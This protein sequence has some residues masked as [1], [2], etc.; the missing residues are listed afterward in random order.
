[1]KVVK[2]VNNKACEL[3][4]I[5]LKLKGVK[6]VSGYLESVHR[7]KWGKKLYCWQGKNNM[8]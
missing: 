4:V 1:M 2:M 6:T 7:L 8:S 3:Q 5:K